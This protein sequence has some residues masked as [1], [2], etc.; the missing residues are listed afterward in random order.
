M[1]ETELE[2]TLPSDNLCVVGQ[3][4]D[5]SAGKVYVHDGD[6]VYVYD[7]GLPIKERLTVWERFVEWC[8]RLGR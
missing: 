4:W 3:C 2:F 5:Y 8:R 1:S 6:K 7:M